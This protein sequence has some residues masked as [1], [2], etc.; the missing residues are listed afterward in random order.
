MFEKCN[1]TLDAKEEELA[2]A[3]EPVTDPKKQESTFQK[4]LFEY[5][6][7]IYNILIGFFF[8]GLNGV[9]GPMFGWFIIKCLF[10]MILYSPDYKDLNA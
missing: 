10:A 1:E 8:Q 3:L 6:K 7:P 5:N 2:K 9:L 4:K